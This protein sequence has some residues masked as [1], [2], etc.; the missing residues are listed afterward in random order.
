MEREAGVH[1][2]PVLFRGEL[3]VLPLEG[4]APLTE[5]FHVMDY[6]RLREPPAKFIGMLCDT[7]LVRYIK[8]LLPLARDVK[9]GDR[10]LVFQPDTRY[11]V[12]DEQGIIRWW[13]IHACFRE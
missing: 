13:E 10:K 7:K 4:R 8:P 12:V 2:D 9:G 11:I 3:D 6:I 5:R 1:S